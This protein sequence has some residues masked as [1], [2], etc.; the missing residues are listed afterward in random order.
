MKTKKANKVAA[1]RLKSASKFLKEHNKEM[2]Y[3]EM[4][5]A[6]WGYLS[7]KLNMPLSVLNKD[8]IEVE[9]RSKGVD[10]TLIKELD[11]KSVV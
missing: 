4:I 5:K 2:F 7:D 6:I 9:L 1:K 3:D 8:N 10:D 11:R